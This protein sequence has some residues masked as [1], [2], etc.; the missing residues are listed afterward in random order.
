[1]ATAMPG[2]TFSFLFVTADEFP[3]FRPDVEVLFGKELL[4]RGHRID[5]IMR[6]G[7][8]VEQS[9]LVEWRGCRVWLARTDPGRRRIDRLRKHLRSLANELRAPALLR[10]GQYD[11]VQVKDKFLIAPLLLV[12]ARR[13]RIPFFY[14]LSFP[15]PEASLLQA[16]TPGARYRFFKLLR[17]LVFRTIL[18]GVIARWADHIF[19]QS[20]EMKRCMS[21]RGVP[22]GKMTAVPMGVDLESAEAPQDGE[23]G[24]TTGS[25]PRIV[26]LGSLERMRRLEFLLGAFARVAERRPDARLVLVGDAHEPE[27][28]RFLEREAARRG[29]AE[30]VEFT[31]FLP[32]AEAFA[33]VRS[34]AVCVSPIPPDPIYD[35][36]S[37]TKLLEY[38]LFARPVV[39]NDQPDQRLVIEESGGGYC[40]P[41][42]A[43]A[44]ADAIVR[45]LDEPDRAREMG[46][47]GFD[48]VRRKRSY[49]SIADAV[50]SCYRRLVTQDC[51][52]PAHAEQP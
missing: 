40:T 23:P 6:A 39:A 41:Y 9:G 25:G 47:R 30:R 42:D 20:E 43:A 44:F 14:W 4:R 15:Y 48:Y 31:G 33:H 10:T 1:M 36:A 49:R 52:A 46:L 7:P 8:P 38:M 27:D 11:F 37:P 21:R 26:Y 19:V 2:S 3:P 16:R 12:A 24:G 18:Y 45:L 28:R 22:A 5:W 32:R 34:A 29:I 51:G 13:R 17:Y 35:V 50:E